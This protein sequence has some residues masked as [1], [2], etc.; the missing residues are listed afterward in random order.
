LRNSRL[1]YQKGWQGIWRGVAFKGWDS[2]RADSGGG[3]GF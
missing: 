3:Y 2:R 1:G